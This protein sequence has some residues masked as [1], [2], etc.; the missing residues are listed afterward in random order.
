[1]VVFIQKSFNAGIEC[2]I[3]LSPLS[4]ELQLGSI[5]V[6]ELKLPPAGLDGVAQPI[7]VEAGDFR[8]SDLPAVK[9]MSVIE[10][11]RLCD[12]EGKLTVVLVLRSR[13]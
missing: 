13:T 7:L 8:R 1:M 9:R 12:G 3:G 4:L 2:S 6:G 10:T 5:K 11:L